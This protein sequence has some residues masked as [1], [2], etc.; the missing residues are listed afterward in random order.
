M[1]SPAAV[2]TAIEQQAVLKTGAL[3][4]LLPPK[5]ISRPLPPLPSRSPSPPIHPGWTR[6]TYTLPAAFPRAYKGST[7]KPGVPRAPFPP[8][9]EKGRINPKATF[10]ALVEPQVEG[11]LKAVN[12]GDEKELDEQEQLLVVVNRYRPQRKREEKGLT[13][14]FSHANGFYKEVWEP[15]LSSLLQQLEKDDRSLPVEEIWALDCFNQGE[16][17]ILNDNVLGD[18]FNWEDHGRDLLNFVISYIDSPTLASSTSSSTTATLSPASNV[19]LSLLSLDTSSP[20]PG[21]SPPTARTY[22]DRLIV[23]IGHSL[24]GG[25]T[26]YAATA[27][28]SLFSSVVLVDPVLPKPD[29]PLRPM[30]KL[31]TGAL[32]RKEKWTS[33]KEAMEGFS[34]KPFFTAWD[35]RILDGYVEFGLKDVESGA[36]LTCTARNEALT[37]CDPMAVAARRACDR[38]KTLPRALPVHF[39]MADAHRSVLAEDLIDHLVN[40]AVPHASLSRVKDAGHL[41][42]HEKPDEAGRLIAA[43]LQQT[44]PRMEGKA[45]L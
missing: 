12:V 37:F 44:Y 8:P 40:E 41:L 20:L 14:V 7:R 34:K 4:P 33:R 28:P 15:T 2:R 30:E 38:L 42:V 25:A 39:L 11:F 9:D 3:L 23:G 10:E 21:P 13:L 32:I 36:A 27:L 29:G 43:F 17:G 31:T 16:A 22:H 24:G 18:V 6:D 35:K 26:A 19:P 5:R 1:A 45:K